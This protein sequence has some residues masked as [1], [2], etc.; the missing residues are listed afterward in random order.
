[1]PNHLGS[2]VLL[3]DV[4]SITCPDGDMETSQKTLAEVVKVLL[5]KNNSP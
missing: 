5:E 4:G 3:H 1:M 2:N